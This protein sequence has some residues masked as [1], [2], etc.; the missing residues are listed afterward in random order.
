MKK[1]KMFNGKILEVG[2]KI[3]FADLWQSGDGD[4]EELLE[5]GCVWV[6]NGESD[7][8]IIADFQIIEADEQNLLRTLVKVTDIR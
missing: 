5:S 4:I 1:V 3:Y 6:A 8:S 7:E 2:E